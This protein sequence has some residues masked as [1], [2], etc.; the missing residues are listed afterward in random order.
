MCV[1]ML[2]VW[3]RCACDASTWCSGRLARA[4]RFAPGAAMALERRPCTS[5]G[6]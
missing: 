5:E 1:L 6:R 3:A 2:W 4:K